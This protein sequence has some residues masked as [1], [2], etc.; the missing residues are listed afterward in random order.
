MLGL[1]QTVDRTVLIPRIG[2]YEGTERFTFPKLSC[3]Y[4]LDGRHLPLSLAE[5]MRTALFVVMAIDGMR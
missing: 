3:G 2:G 1:V 5:F 4:H